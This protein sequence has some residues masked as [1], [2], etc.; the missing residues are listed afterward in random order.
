[1]PLASQLAKRGNGKAKCAPRTGGRLPR[2]PLKS[3]TFFAL[4]SIAAAFH[5]LAV[6]SHQEGLRSP[7]FAN[8]NEDDDG[9]E[10]VSCAIASYS[11]GSIPFKRTVPRGTHAESHFTNRKTCS[12]RERNC[13]KPHS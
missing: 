1:M 3:I 5:A 8:T 7:R 2:P 9:D 12:E 6:L 13:S 11:M 10:R 4:M